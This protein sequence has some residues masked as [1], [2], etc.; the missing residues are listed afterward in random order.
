[1]AR[2]SGSRGTS[3]PLCPLLYG[4]RRGI[5]WGNRAKTV[6]FFGRPPELLLFGTN[7]P[8]CPFQNTEQNG[9]VMLALWAGSPAQPETAGGTP[10]KTGAAGRRGRKNGAAIRPRQ[11]DDDHAERYDP[12]AGRDRR[13]QCADPVRGFPRPGGAQSGGPG[14]D[15]QPRAAAKAAADHHPDPAGQPRQ[16]LLP[17]DPGR[18]RQHRYRPLGALRRQRGGTKAA[19]RAPGGSAPWRRSRASIC[20]GRWA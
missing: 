12:P 19:P 20:P 15:V 8:G 10:A 6:Q 18:G 2:R 14:A 16:R 17:A 1:M 4:R 11:R 7:R 3:A 5:S 9:M 13:A